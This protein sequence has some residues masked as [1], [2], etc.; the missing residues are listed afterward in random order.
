MEDP[1]GYVQSKFDRFPN[2]LRITTNFQSK[3]NGMC[4]ST[5]QV[6][7]ADT[8]RSLKI[9][10]NLISIENTFN[11]VQNKFC[12]FWNIP[13]FN[14]NFQ[15]TSD[16][17]WNP[18]FHTHS[19]ATKMIERDVY[20]FSSDRGHCELYSNR[21][22]RFGDHYTNYRE[23]SKCRSVN[24]FSGHQLGHFKFLQGTRWTPLFPHIYPTAP[25]IGRHISQYFVVNP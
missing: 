23:F 6:F 17:R 21:V 18:H 25:S 14:T 3:P 1:V 19:T 13:W 15:S 22:W 11:Y 4:K 8:E 2:I 5:F 7:L 20:H 24:H 10:N 16:S 9:S 12:P